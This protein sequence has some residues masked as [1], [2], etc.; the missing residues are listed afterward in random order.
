MTPGRWP[1]TGSER[2]KLDLLNPVSLYHL[3]HFLTFF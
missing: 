3:Y 2:H 1:Q